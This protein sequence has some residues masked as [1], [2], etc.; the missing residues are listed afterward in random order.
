MEIRNVQIFTEQQVF[1]EGNIKIED[2]LFADPEAPDSAGEVLEGEGLYAIPGLIDMHFHGCMGHD[3]CDGTKE[4]LRAIAEYEASV[5]VTAIAPA[6]M[7]LPV[8]DLEQVLSTAADYK[9]Q[10][11]EMSAGADLIGVNMEG[12]FISKEKKGAQDEAY[13]IPS[14]LEVFHRFQKAARGLVKLIAVAPEIEGALEFVEQAKDEIKISVA[15]TN[16]DY[17]SALAA[18]K[19]GASH[20]VH[21][22]NAMPPFGHRE[23]GVIGAVADS[24]HVTAE[25]ICDGV[26]IHPAVVRAAFRM[27]GSDRIILISDSMRAAGMPDGDYDLGGQKVRVSKRRATL[28]SN[29]ALAG[30]AVNLMDCLRTVVKEMGIPLEQAA[31]CATANP[32]KCLG[33]YHRYGSIT[34][35]KK[36]N[37]VL[38]DQELNVR[39][40]IKDG[41]R[42]PVGNKSSL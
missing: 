42:I 20:G 25:L 10:T 12:P 8:E 4:A 38:L 34:P 6:I 33:E 37:V 1:Q 27:L 19:K 5:G 9:E 35:G 18:F 29:G 3:F 22:F 32:A 26:H 11:G 24:S 28:I 30:S 13:I 15:H 31:A 21:L 16:A 14:S 2:G 40:V 41:R 36:A 23:P 17:D 7:T 39:E